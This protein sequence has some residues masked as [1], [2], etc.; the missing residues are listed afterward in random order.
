[1]EDKRSEAGRRGGESPGRSGAS[2]GGEEAPGRDQA[3]VGSGSGPTGDRSVKTRTPR[4][5]E[6]G[7]A[8]AW[9]ADSTSDGAMGGGGAGGAA[10]LTGDGS[11]RTNGGKS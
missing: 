6:G 2:A 9:D 5:E 7:P 10:G 1:M 8:E 3:G 11:G 4:F